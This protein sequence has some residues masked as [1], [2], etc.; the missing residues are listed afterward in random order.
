MLSDP[1]DP[2][3]VNVRETPLVTAWVGVPL[4][5][6]VPIDTSDFTSVNPAGKFPEASVKLVAE[7]W[8]SKFKAK[9]T[10]TCPDAVATAVITG[11]GAT[12]I[13]L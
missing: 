12:V 3:A 7:G 10:P 9:G 11:A 1:V 2:T 4:T 5:V 13:T 6:A 8:I